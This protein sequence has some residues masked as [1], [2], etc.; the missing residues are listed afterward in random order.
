MGIVSLTKGFGTVIDIDRHSANLQ[1]DNTRGRPD[2]VCNLYIGPCLCIRIHD[3]ASAGLSSSISTLDSANSS[4]DFV[5]VTI[6][7][8]AWDAHRLH[9]RWDFS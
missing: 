5:V 7:A 8:S 3:E 2:R 9:R 6:L 4:P 1:S